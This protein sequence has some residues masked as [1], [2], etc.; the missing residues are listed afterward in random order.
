MEDGGWMNGGWRKHSSEENHLSKW[1]FGC[2]LGHRN[3]KTTQYFRYSRLRPDRVIILEEWIER[4]IQHPLREEQQ[5]D[6]RIRRWA[7]IPEMG[8]RAL[9][10]ILLEDG[11]TIHNA[12]FDRDFKE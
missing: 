2:M 5:A 9:R 4:V 6:R 8:N 12:F 7:R 11:E 1:E 10:V 3:M